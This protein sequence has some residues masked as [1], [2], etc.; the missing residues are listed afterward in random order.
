MIS[1]RPPAERIAPSQA[2][3]PQRQPAQVEPT[4]AHRPPET[5]AYQPPPVPPDAPASSAWYVPWWAFALVILAVAGITVGLWGLVLMNRGDS[6]AGVGPTPTPIFV[7]ITSTP[8]LAPPAGDTTPLVTPLPDAG[9]P[10]T[11]APALTPTEGVDLPITVGSFVQ[12]AGTEGVGVAVRQGPGLTYTYFFVGQDGDVFT[13]EGGP[14]DSDGYT[15][16]Q[17]LDPNDPNRAGW[18]VE[19]YLEVLEP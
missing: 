14:R 5:R 12:V 6:L 9:V 16:W 17:I 3:Y 18:V 13:V 7:V 15:W 2:G 4:R 11:Q 10:T 8:T 1:K 19:D